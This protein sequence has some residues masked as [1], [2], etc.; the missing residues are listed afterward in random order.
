MTRPGAAKIWILAGLALCLV[1][2]FGAGA[3]AQMVLAPGSAPLAKDSQSRTEPGEAAVN[4][5]LR[6]AMYEALAD[7]LGPARME[8]A[9]PLVA[10]PIMESPHNHI[11]GF[12]IKA[13]TKTETRIHVLV[14]AK[15]NSAALKAS[16]KAVG[17][18]QILKVR[19]LPLMGIVVGQAP[20]Y[21]WWLSPDQS[22]PVSL[23][24]A[25]LLKRLEALGCEIVA[26]G[27]RPVQPPGPEPNDEDAMVIGQQYNAEVAL[28]G[29]IDES[30]ELSGRTALISARLVDVETGRM[31]ASAN[32]LGGPQ[33]PGA[34]KPQPAEESGQAGED[35]DNA[36]PSRD[37]FQ[38]PEEANLAGEQVAEELVA[39]LK[40][41]GWNLA[42]EP[43]QITIVL[44]GIKRYS[45][46]RAFL[47]T[48]KR[49]P[50]HVQDVRQ[51]SI[52]GGQATFSAMIPTS[53]RK[54][55][56]L[57]LS[58]DFPDFFLSVESLSPEELLVTLVPK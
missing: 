45:D 50:Q 29:R 1:L 6:A 21:T 3:G 10:G 55:A 12:Q 58:E 40:R 48:L 51:R 17:L 37:Q 41:A 36:P 9:L 28:I 31:L 16:L 56:D 46:M 13:K 15:I 5:A 30:D 42:T 43:R 11:L 18:G 19:V 14:E 44:S 49:Y 57:L 8:N 23:A 47:E 4:D 20:S 53:T 38:Q 26:P 33:R 2:G 34:D 24:M 32:E 7:I 25:A 54:L 52:K 35:S 22:P 39:Q 27:E